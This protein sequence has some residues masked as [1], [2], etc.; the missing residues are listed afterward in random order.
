VKEI[1]WIAED[2]N[3][4]IWM[5]H[6]TK[7]GKSQIAPF[8]LIPT[9][10]KIGWKSWT[11][12]SAIPSNFAF[13]TEFPAQV[14]VSHIGELDHCLN[15]MVKPNDSRQIESYAEGIGLVKVFTP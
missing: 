10:P 5:I 4:N 7:N 9:Q 12:A 11:S 13:A 1:R 2:S 6:S 3:Q 15:L 8:I 14:R